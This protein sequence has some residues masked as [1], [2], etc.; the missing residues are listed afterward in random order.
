MASEHS[1]EETALELHGVILV[2]FSVCSQSEEQVIDLRNCLAPPNLSQAYKAALQRL[3]PLMKSQRVNEMIQKHL[4]PED[5]LL[6]A[7]FLND[8]CKLIV[9]HKNLTSVVY[10]FTQGILQTLAETWLRGY[11]HTQDITESQVQY[12]EVIHRTSHI[13]YILLLRCKN[14]AGPETNTEVPKTLTETQPQ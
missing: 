2:P 1:Q 9:S 4:K 8:L 5:S 12:T 13:F 7:D 14:M 6:Y 11:T 3:G 10:W